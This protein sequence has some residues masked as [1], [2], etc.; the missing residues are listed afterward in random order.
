[1]M[2]QLAG[3]GALARTVRSARARTRRWAG[4]ITPLVEFRRRQRVRVGYGQTEPLDYRPSGSFLFITS[5]GAG[6]GHISRMLA[7][8]TRLP[9]D[10]DPVILTLSKAY[11]Q[12]QGLGVEVRYFPSAAATDGDA[13][14]WNHG[15]GRHLFELMKELRP[16]V[17]MF[18][19]TWI[20]Q[21]V[22]DVCRTLGIHLVWMQRGCWRPEVDRNS[23]QR[24]L[25][26]RV[27][28]EV[29]VP[30]DYGCRE[31]VDVGPG[32]PV[33]YVNPVTLTGP[34]DLLSREE[35][36]ADLGFDSSRRYVLIS[37]G[38]GI[39]FDGEKAVAAALEAVLSLGPEWVPVMTRNPLAEEAAVDERL[40]VMSAYPLARYYRA[41]EFAVTAAGY[42]SVQEAIALDLPSILLPND[43]TVTDDQVRRALSVDEEG[44][45]RTVRSAEGLREAITA[46]AAGDGRAAE[47]PLP[48]DGGAQAAELLADRLRAIA[49]M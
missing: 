42:N 15:F 6:L 31:M 32:V 45:A 16:S 39:L 26:A 13:D 25:A 21:P 20:Y 43:R 3:R 35:A 18:D 8:A 1:M 11:T 9:S 23:P 17:V 2:P 40:Q 44:L 48:A 29:I 24:H 46:Q 47:A 12:V 5:N 37:L 4:G 19:G 33:H 10:R 49:A 30:G 41:F 28:D 27:C 36:C 38:G 14:S 34:E 7:V 22:T